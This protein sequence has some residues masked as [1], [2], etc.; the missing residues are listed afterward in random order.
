ML[1]SLLRRKEHDGRY[2]YKSGASIILLLS[3]QTTSDKN[4]NKTEKETVFPSVFD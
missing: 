4:S 3:I 2:K 1:L